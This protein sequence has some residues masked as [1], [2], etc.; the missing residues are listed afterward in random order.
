MSPSLRGWAF[1]LEPFTD[2]NK[3]VS[4]KTKWRYSYFYFQVRSGMGYTQTIQKTIPHIRNSSDRKDYPCSH[5]LPK[6]T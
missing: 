5:P 2:S 6:E 1:L 4:I 3:K